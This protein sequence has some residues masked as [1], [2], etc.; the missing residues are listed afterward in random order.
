[1]EENSYC[2]IVFGFIYNIFFDFFLI[3]DDN[4]I[5]FSNLGFLMKAF[6]KMFIWTMLFKYI[7]GEKIVSICSFFKQII[8]FYLYYKNKR[9]SYCPFSSAHK[10]LALLKPLKTLNWVV[11]SSKAIVGGILWTINLA[12]IY[13]RKILSLILGFKIKLNF[14]K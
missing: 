4:L 5:Y 8:N 10:K 6:L 9:N 2:F 1:M 7:I 3:S 12:D 13:G 11:N 14:P